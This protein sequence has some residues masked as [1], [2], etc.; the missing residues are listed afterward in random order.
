MHEFNNVWNTKHVKSARMIGEAIG[1]CH[2][3]GNSF[4]YDMIMNV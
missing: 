2:P 4:I 1:K 3:H